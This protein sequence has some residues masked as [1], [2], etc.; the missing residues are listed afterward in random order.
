MNFCLIV[1]L[2]KQNRIHNFTV[3][4]ILSVV[5]SDD[6]SQYSPVLLRHLSVI[7]VDIKGPIHSFAAER[8]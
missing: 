8:G 6:D 3:L 1:V 7:L 2:F 5:T 4:H